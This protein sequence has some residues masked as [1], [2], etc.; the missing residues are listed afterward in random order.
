MSQLV[1][2]IGLR[3]PRARVQLRNPAFPHSHPQEW[4]FDP[5]TG[6]TL[7]SSSTA[8]KVGPYA[9]YLPV[10]EPL[11]AYVAL[12]I[13]PMVPGT[14]AAV[15]DRDDIQIFRQDMVDHDQAWAEADFGLWCVAAQPRVE[16]T[17]DPVTGERS[18]P[19][20]R[21]ADAVVWAPN[22][23]RPLIGAHLS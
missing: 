7:W 3:V 8:E 23:P 10:N 21:S 9:V 15:P 20:P 4:N 13:S 12:S 19:E 18:T 2:L 1:A 17:Y 16:W 6:D 22:T 5:K 14:M 11:Y